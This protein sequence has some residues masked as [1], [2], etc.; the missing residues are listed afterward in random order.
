MAK[1]RNTGGLR[2][3]ALAHTRVVDIR[4]FTIGKVHRDVLPNVSARC[5]VQSRIQSFENGSRYTF[6][7]G[8]ERAIDRPHF[9]LLKRNLDDSR[10]AAQCK[11][12][13]SKPGDGVVE[14]NW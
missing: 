12:F 8:D 9:G 6:L 5:N 4:E 2:C 11:P 1:E 3:S 13:A 7:R 10:S 14:E